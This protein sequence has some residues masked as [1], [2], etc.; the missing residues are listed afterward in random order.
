MKKSRRNKDTKGEKSR[1]RVEAP[2]NKRKKKRGEQ[3][4][5]NGE[6]KVFWV[7]K[8]WAYGLQL[9]EYERK[10]TDLSVLKQI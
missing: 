3:T 2:G 10:G 5:S 7:W 9:Q 1:E 8:I 6:N 4:E